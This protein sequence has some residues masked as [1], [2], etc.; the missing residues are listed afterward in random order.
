[1][2]L[3]VSHAAQ[4]L[5]DTQSLPPT[6]CPLSQRFPDSFSRTVPLWCAV[7]NRIFE[8]AAAVE[9]AASLE[10]PA[11]DT[12]PWVSP[13]ERDQIAS[14]VDGWIDGLGPD[15]VGVIRAAITGEGEGRGVSGVLHSSW[16]PLRPVWV[17]PRATI[18]GDSEPVAV[19]A[20]DVER[21]SASRAAAPA[22]ETEGG[23]TVWSDMLPMFEAV[24]ASAADGSAIGGGDADALGAGIGGGDVAS[25]GLDR[26]A[27]ATGADTSRGRAAAADDDDDATSSVDYLPVICV[28]ASRHVATDEQ[29]AMH[30]WTYVQ[31]A[32][33]DEETWAAGLTAPVFWAHRDALLEVDGERLDE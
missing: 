7:L 33:D 28:S 18:A 32:G 17:C 6:V 2:E 21:S 19:V 4:K 3:S 1:M 11:V 25:P 9:G 24:P 15:L 22:G 27:V 13:S 16:K 14:R 29:R 10:S 20:A 23:D 31:G 8:R 26:R 5:V 30:S 12:P